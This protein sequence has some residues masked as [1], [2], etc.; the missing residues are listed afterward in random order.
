MAAGSTASSSAATSP[1]P[2]LPSGCA[3]AARAAST[4]LSP[5]RPPCRTSHSPGY[6]LSWRSAPSSG[7]SAPAGSGRTAAPSACAAVSRT[8][9]T[10]CGD[11][12]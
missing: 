7:G 4:Y 2:P 9:A 6:S 1:R 10:T 11:T 3:A 8:G 12:A 5:S